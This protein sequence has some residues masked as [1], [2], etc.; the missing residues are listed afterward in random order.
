[1]NGVKQLDAGSRLKWLI[2][3]QLACLGCLLFLL[4]PPGSCWVSDNGNKHIILENFEINRS[5]VIENPAAD[6]DPDNR[7]FPG[8]FH[9]LQRDKEMRS[10]YPIY[11]S[12]FTQPF[13]WLFGD[14]GLLVLPLASYILLLYLTARR[15]RSPWVLLLLGTGTPLL[16]Y[17]GTFWEMLP[18]CVVAFLAAREL[19]THGKRHPIRAGLIL[20]VGLIL[21][22][23][24]YFLVAALGGALMVT[25]GRRQ[26]LREALLLAG[27][28]ILAALPI[29]CWQYLDSGHILG[30]HGSLY[31]THHRQVPPGLIERAVGVVEGYWLY[32][33]KFYVSGPRFHWSYPLRHLPVVLLAVVGG[34]PRSRDHLVLKRR[35]LLLAIA[36]WVVLIALLWQ[37]PAPAMTAGVTVGL[38]TSTPILAGLLLNWRPLL[39]T[40]APFRQWMAAAALFYVV[41]VPPLLTRT[42]I[43][44]IWGPRHFL[45]VMPLLVYLGCAGL[46]RMGLARRHILLLGVLSA[47]IQCFG[48]VTLVRVCRES[49][50]LTETLRQEKEQVVLTDVFFLPEQTPQLFREKKWLYL[51]EDDDVALVLTRLRENHV[52]EAL[53]VLSPNHRMLSDEALRQ[54][55]AEAPLLAPPEEFHAPASGFLELYIGKIRLQ[56]PR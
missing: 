30:L 37:T 49:A 26:G 42:D 1:M 20:G 38:F 24:M 44:I 4:I 15:F 56:S 55:L 23:E 12:L 50:A 13:H 8:G 46:V 9:F 29:W 2:F 10:I 3:L 39:T 33:F 40:G 43:G 14:R 19:L 31:H 11:F 51:D 34:F 48:V 45:P 52:N 16:F 27:A 7:L 47:A 17:A 22:E 54:L 6:L 21:R 36:A 41:I 35:L 25:G 53:L 18:A 5:E 28:F 32:L